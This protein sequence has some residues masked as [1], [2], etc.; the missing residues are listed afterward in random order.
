MN[1]RAG[2]AVRCYPSVLPRKEPAPTGAYKISRGGG[3]IATSFSNLRARTKDGGGVL[4]T[5]KG[6]SSPSSIGTDLTPA[7]PT[8]KRHIHEHTQRNFSTNSNKSPRPRSKDRVKRASP[9]KVLNNCQHTKEQH[10]AMTQFR[11]HRPTTLPVGEGTQPSVG[12]VSCIS[13]G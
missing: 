12:A 4:C 8:K 1:H 13:S 6:S 5:R 2:T 7:V 3:V 11:R 9:R 10:R